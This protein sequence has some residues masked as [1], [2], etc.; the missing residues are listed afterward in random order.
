MCL[1]M[2]LAHGNL[3]YRQVFVMKDSVGTVIN[4]DVNAKEWTDQGRCEYGF[5][6]NPSACECDKSFDFGEYL[7]YVNFKCREKLIN[8]LVEK[9]DEDIDGNEMVFNVTLYD[10]R[11][12]CRSCMQCIM[13]S[14]IAFVLIIMGTSGVSFYFYLYVNRNVASY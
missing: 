6:M 5:I 9:C 10:Y 3:D 2:R 7:H 13:L 4:K 8:E 11:K 1:V 12:V 14:I